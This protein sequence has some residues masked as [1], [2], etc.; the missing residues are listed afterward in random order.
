MFKMTLI[1]LGLLLIASCTSTSTVAVGGFSHNNSGLGRGSLLR[2][3]RAFAIAQDAVT[4][5]Q[6]VVGQTTIQLIRANNTTEAQR[7]L[8]ACIHARDQQC[9]DDF[10]RMGVTISGYGTGFNSFGGMLPH[11]LDDGSYYQR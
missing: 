10:T 1:A 7:Q 6:A 5:N 2:D 3:A 11:Q 9:V 4:R 8:I